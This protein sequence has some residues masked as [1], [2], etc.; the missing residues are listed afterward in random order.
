MENEIY[1]MKKPGKGMSTSYLFEVDGQEQI[2]KVEFIPQLSAE[3]SMYGRVEDNRKLS[4]WKKLVHEKD[5]EKKETE[6]T[7]V[8]R[9]RVADPII[10]DAFNPGTTAGDLFIQYR[11]ESTSGFRG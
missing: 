9:L 8:D 4:T 5:P 6:P 2:V 1:N 10:R 3:H 11:L 7:L